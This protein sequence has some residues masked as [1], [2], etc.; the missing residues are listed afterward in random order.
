MVFT[1]S[2][3]YPVQKIEAVT[4]DSGRLYKV[5]G[6]KEYESITT[7]LGKRPGK[8]EAL[9]EWRRRVGWDEA[10]RISRKASSRGTA[11]HTIIE[12]YLDNIDLDECVKGKMPDAVIMFKS[13]QNILDRS[14]E[15]IYMQEAPLWTHEYKLAGRV[16]CVADVLKKLSIVDFKT[17][18]KP[19][20]REW[21]ED[22]FLQGAAY[23]YM[24]EEMYDKRIEQ[25]V[26]FVAVEDRDPQIFMDDPYKYKDHNFFTERL[27]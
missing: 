27:E 18:M 15:K 16:D 21:V 7:A 1:H 11:V 4:T 23:S 6:G 22:Y 26:L 12:H 5:P 2:D 25:V 14:I 17:S 9:A 19:K 10:N 24:F 8:K 20:K 13:L 3:E